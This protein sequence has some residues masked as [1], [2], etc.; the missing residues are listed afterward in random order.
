MPTT[1]LIKN[2]WNLPK[3]LGGKQGNVIL[4]Y[5]MSYELHVYIDKV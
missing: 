4:I 3:F 5:P 2:F 1:K